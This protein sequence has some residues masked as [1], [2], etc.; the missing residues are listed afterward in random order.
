MNA[1]LTIASILHPT[2]ASCVMSYLISIL[3]GLDHFDHWL[4]KKINGQ[5]TNSFFDFIFLFFRQSYFWMPLY[6]FLFIFISF[7]F[8]VNLW[9]WFIL[10]LC[11]VPLTDMVG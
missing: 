9:F 6:L 3:Q 1:I 2:F 5:W 4:F 8:E 7:N 11:T 10:F